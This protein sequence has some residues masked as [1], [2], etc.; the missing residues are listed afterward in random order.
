M[1]APEEKKKQ[2][3]LKRIQEKIK[4]Y[5][6]LVIPLGET[7]ADRNRPSEQ[8]SKKCPKNGWH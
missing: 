4:N 6:D 3:A 8:L 5:R 2:E 1:R 7:P